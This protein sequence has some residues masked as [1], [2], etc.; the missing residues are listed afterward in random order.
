[1]YESTVLSWFERTLFFIGFV[2]GKGVSFDDLQKGI[3]TTFLTL[4]LLSVSM[5]A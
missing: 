2:S 5:F 1:M 3:I 4:I